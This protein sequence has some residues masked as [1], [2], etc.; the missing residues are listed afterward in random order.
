MKIEVCP[1]CNRNFMENYASKNVRGVNRYYFKGDLDHHYS[2][3]EIPALALSFFNLV[4][5]CKVCNHEKLQS[6]QRTFYP[7]Y[8]YEDEEYHFSIELYTKDDEK[9]IIYE[10]NIEDIESKRYDSTVWQGV[11]D[12][13]KIKL[14]GGNR[15]QLSECMQNSND[16]FHLEKKY[17]HS[18]EYVKEIIRKKYI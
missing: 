13:F 6:T 16:I 15:L 1:Y 17:N 18:K 5:S 14:R 2:K 10:K 4:P 3:D 12:N 11:S 9:D 8:D 7:Y